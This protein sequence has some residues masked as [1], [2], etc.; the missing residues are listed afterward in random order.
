MTQDLD[1]SP[2]CERDN[3]AEDCEIEITPEMILAGAEEV[4]RRSFDLACDP[5]FQSRSE[6]SVKIHEMRAASPV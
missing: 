1:K 6:I 5:S 4:E 3:G 2:H